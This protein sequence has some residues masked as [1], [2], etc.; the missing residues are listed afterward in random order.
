MRL[1]PFICLLAGLAIQPVRA[2]I[3]LSILSPNPNYRRN[4]ECATIPA[5]PLRRMPNS[6]GDSAICYAY[7]ATDM[8]SQRIGLAVSAL[9]VAS[10]FY[11]ADPSG[12]YSAKDKRVR[13]F[14][15]ERP[16]LMD[17]IVAQRSRVD[18]SGE[19]IP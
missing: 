19:K 14:F 15:A 17:E 7:A 2:Q 10:T 18:V 13:E 11:F 3:D 1:S 12:L 6:Q 16:R 4:L 5:P 9:D 8:I